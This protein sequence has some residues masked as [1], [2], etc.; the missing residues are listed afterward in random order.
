MTAPVSHRAYISV[1]PFALFIAW[2]VAWNCNLAL[3]GRIGWGPDADTVYWIVMKLAIW[4]VPVLLWIRLAEGAP[5]AA[6]LEMRNVAAGLRWGL[7]VGAAIVVVNY[8][9]KTLPSGAGL[10]LPPFDLAVVNAAVVAPLVEEL[11]LRG[12]LQKRLEL[13]GHRVWSANLLTTVV[14]VAMHLP[15]WYFQG[16]TTTLAGYTARLVPLA[17]LSLTFGWTKHRSG[18]LYGAILAHTINN[19]DSVLLP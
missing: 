7:G 8:V 17:V 4:V 9:G 11:T 5:L 14:F 3:R 15:G 18:S 16:R 19:L 1:Y 12:F 10:R 6:F 13:N 2:V